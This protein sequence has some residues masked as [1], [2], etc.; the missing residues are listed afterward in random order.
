MTKQQKYLREFSEPCEFWTSEDGMLVSLAII[1]GEGAIDK[2]K[3]HFAFAKQTFDKKRV[4]K[5][6]AYQEWVGS[7]YFD[8][9]SGQSK[10]KVWR[11]Y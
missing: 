5:R 11:H 2:L 10:G 1:P 4:K 9:G 8:G 3:S 7:E 6:Y